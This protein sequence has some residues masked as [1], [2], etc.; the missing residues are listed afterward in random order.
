MMA[1]TRLNARGIEADRNQVVAIQARSG[2]VS[3]CTRRLPQPLGPSAWLHAVKVLIIAGLKVWPELSG[4][5][6]KVV[7]DARADVDQSETREAA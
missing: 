5:L 1:D 7:A 2:F 3:I 4:A 6:G